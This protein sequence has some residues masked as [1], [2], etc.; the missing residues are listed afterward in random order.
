[1]ILLPNPTTKVI[2]FLLLWPP[3]EIVEIVEGEKRQKKNKI[4]QIFLEYGPA[5]IM[6]PFS[7][8]KLIVS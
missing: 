2:Y 6:G 3:P 7:F 1:M 4:N 8:V 5:Q